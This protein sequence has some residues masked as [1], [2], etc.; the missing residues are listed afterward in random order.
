MVNLNMCTVHFIGNMEK[1]VQLFYRNYKTPTSSVGG[2]RPRRSGYPSREQEA[3]ATPQSAASPARPALPFPVARRGGGV[4]CEW[5][6]GRQR[7]DARC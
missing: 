4:I 3:A 5:P 2:A 7:E 6:A 1:S